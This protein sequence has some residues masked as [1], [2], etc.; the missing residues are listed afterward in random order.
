MR[1]N[2]LLRMELMAECLG[3]QPT[4][5]VQAKPWSLSSS[6]ILPQ[7]HFVLLKI[8]APV[9]RAIAIRSSSGL[10][11]FPTLAIYSDYCT[12]KLYRFWQGLQKLGGPGIT[13]YVALVKFLSENARGHL[14]DGTKCLTKNRLPTNAGNNKSQFMTIQMHHHAIISNHLIIEYETKQFRHVIILRNIHYKKKIYQ[15]WLF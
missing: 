5:L 9:Q 2:D 1:V 11:K 12:N 8:L 7:R 4:F 13:V 14:E 6:T 10:S 3:K 15:I